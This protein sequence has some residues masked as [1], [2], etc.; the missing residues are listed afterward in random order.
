MAKVVHS[1]HLFVRRII[2]A[3]KKARNLHSIIHVSAETKKDF[4]WWIK[5]VGTH[6]GVKWFPN[7]V[8]ESNSTLL[9][10]DASDTAAA[11]VVDVKWTILYFDG[12]YRWVKEKSINYREMLAVVLGVSTLGKYL[13]NKGVI[14]NIENK[15]CHKQYK[16]ESRKTK[17]Q[18]V[19]YGAYTFIP[20]QTMFSTRQSS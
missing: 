15:A 13:Q 19:S 20:A 8:T 14:M 6:N 9:F 3:A 7:I 2:N 17:T 18:W 4:L 16:Q 12:K 1:G 5:C 10:T 11:A